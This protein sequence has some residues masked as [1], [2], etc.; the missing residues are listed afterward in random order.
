VAAI[1]VPAGV[2]LNLD[3]RIYRA[4]ET[5]EVD[6]LTVAFLNGERVYPWQW[7]YAPL[8]GPP[9]SGAQKSPPEWPAGIAP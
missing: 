9:A 5:V 8:E 6:D 2:I 7:G 3:G 1:T 4:G